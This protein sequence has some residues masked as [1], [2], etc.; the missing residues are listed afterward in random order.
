VD[1]SAEKR[2]HDRA[3]FDSVAGSLEIVNQTEHEHIRFEALSVVSS[4]S[5][6]CLLPMWPLESGDDSVVAFWFDGWSNSC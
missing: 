2:G 5:A 1:L 6:R 3:R 4:A